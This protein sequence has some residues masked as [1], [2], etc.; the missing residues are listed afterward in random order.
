VLIYGSAVDLSSYHGYFLESV[1]VA[2]APRSTAA[3]AMTRG[4]G[5][6]AVLTLTHVLHLTMDSPGDWDD[7][8]DEISVRRLPRT[9]SWPPEARH[10]LQHHNNDSDLLWIRLTGP[11][12]IEIVA[13]TLAAG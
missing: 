6:H 9:G 8:I 4:A 13:R 7:F 5:E 10:L 11:T 2:T 1:T 3:I 12:Q